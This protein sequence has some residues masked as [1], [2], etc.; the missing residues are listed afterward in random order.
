MIKAPWARLTMFST[1]QTRARPN[2]INVYRPPNSTP[3]AR[4]CKN[5]CTVRLRAG[6]QL[7]L[8][9]ASPP[10]PRRHGVHRFLH[11]T[12]RSVHC[13][14]ITVLDLDHGFWQCNLALFAKA[15]PAVQAL[16]IDLR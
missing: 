6:G 13:H 1:P 11:K 9:P 12:L 5:S 15:D 4:I 8:K 16:K 14:Q 2:A 3:F 10:A 7:R